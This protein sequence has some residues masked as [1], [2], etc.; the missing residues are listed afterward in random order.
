MLCLHTDVVYTRHFERFM[1]TNLNSKISWIPHDEKENLNEGKYLL[2]IDV[3]TRV[4]EDVE[5]TLN[6]YKHQGKKFTSTALK[7]VR[8]YH[9]HNILCILMK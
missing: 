9:A 5:S 4:P 1:K 2:L 8:R 3:K 6:R 7:L